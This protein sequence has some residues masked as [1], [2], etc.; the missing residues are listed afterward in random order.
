MPSSKFIGKPGITWGMVTSEKASYRYKLCN[1]TYSSGAPTIFPYNFNILCYLNSKVAEY[2]L[3]LL[4]PTL[5]TPIG[6]IGK[7]PVVNNTFN[8]IDKNQLSISKSDWD[9]RETSWDF[10]RSPLITDYAAPRIETVIDENLTDW[11]WPSAFRPGEGI[12][13]P[14]QV[15]SFKRHW[16]ELFLQL[17]RNEEE[18]NRIFIELYGLQE[19]LTPDVP[20]TE[21]TILQDEL[22]DAARKEQRIEFDESVLARQFVSYGVGCLMGRY[23]VEKDGLILADAGATVDD[24]IAKVPG[25][26]FLPDQDAIL[27]LT[28]EDDFADDLPTRFKEWL[29]FLSGQYYEENLSWLE[30]KIGRDIRSYFL[31]DFYKEHV[32]RYKNRPI[33][34]MVSSPSGCFRALVYLHRYTRDTVSKVLNDY[35]RPYR[36]KLV[37]KIRSMDHML[38]ADA[39][40]SQNEKARTLKRK[41]QLEKYLA[42]IDR[43]ERDVLYPLTQQRI[44]L[45]LDDGVKVNYRKL[46]SILEPVK[47]L[48]EKEE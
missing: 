39:S 6:E 5:N 33:Y 44:E 1:S 25:A 29:R 28:D 31:K 8:T 36:E 24:F 35:L 16:T 42:E 14:A 17:H 2:L 3:E 47:Q 48:E 15:E 7:L 12:N 20:Y 4:N 46:S 21:I 41:A 38:D 11:S 23:S 13:L 45:D 34:W 18:N 43:W 10:R 9:L 32:R 26:R 22:V 37:Q 30:S 27:P 40:I 19:E